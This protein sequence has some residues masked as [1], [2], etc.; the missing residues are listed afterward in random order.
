[1]ADSS[2][3]VSVVI[4][5]HNRRN[6]LERALK[7][8]LNQTYKNLEIIVVDDNSSDDTEDYI[9]QVMKRDHRVKYKKI[10]LEETRGGN[11]ARNTGIR[12]A[13]GETVAFLDDDDEWKP[14]KTEIQVNYLNDNTRIKAVSCDLEYVYVIGGKEYVSYSNL[15]INHQPYDFF[16][17]SWMNVTSTMMI[18][19]GILDAIGGFDENIPA[20][21]EIELS[22]RVC[23]SCEVDIIKKPLIRYYQYLG[24]STQITNNVNKYLL[25]LN[26]IET[27]FEKE[28]A[29]LTTDQRQ[30]L[31]QNNIR[32]VSYRYL[33]SNCR[34]EYRKTLKPFLKNNGLKNWLEYILSFLFKYEIITK[35]E[36]KLYVLKK[37]K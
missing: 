37:R 23:M 20:I 7:S 22:Y 36:S 3:L 6:L 30:R 12:M 2:W 14:D 21:Q 5:T 19:K 25:A 15:K 31:E 32:N 18:Y 17:S 4:T 9:R 1:M 8:V 26:Y 35:L 33:R 27:K 34:K 16:V 11:Y 13:S 29:C 28:L 10:P 24:N